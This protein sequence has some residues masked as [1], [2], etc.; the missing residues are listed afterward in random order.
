[1]ARAL[2][3]YTIRTTRAPGEERDTTVP[4]IVDRRDPVDLATVV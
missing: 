4:V 3:N 2:I 1:M